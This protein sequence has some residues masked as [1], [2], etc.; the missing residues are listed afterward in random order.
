MKI[1][2]DPGH[3][4]N[5]ND[6]GASGNG[7]KESTLALSISKKIKVELEKRGIVV[8]MSR[9][10]ENDCH[11]LPQRTN[12]ANNLKVDL[13]LSVHINSA[14]NKDATGIEVLYYDEQAFATDM[15]NKMCNETGAKNRGAKKRTDL[16]VLNATTMSALLVECGF[17]SNVGESKLLTDTNY[18]DKLVKGI[19]GAI[20]SKYKIIVD[21]K[22]TEYEKALE[23]LVGAN[24]VGSPAAWQLDKININNVPSL[25]KKM[26]KYV[27]GRS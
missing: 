25:I 24:I 12:K 11:S 19:V 23:T 22:N 9:E 18:Q 15:C 8:Y 7:L 10:T 13:Y 4:N 3:R 17:I 6:F 26:A 16:H 1:L 2:I 5:I 21:D 20:I 27:E 14:S